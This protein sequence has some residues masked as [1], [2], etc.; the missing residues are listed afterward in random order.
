M[1]ITDGVKTVSIKMHVSDAFAGLSPDWSLDFFEA[2]SLHYDEETDTYSVPD[3]EYCIDQAK[4][5]E[6]ESENNIVFVC[7]CQER[8][9]K[10]MTIRELAAYM[11]EHS[12]VNPVPEIDEDTA[13]KYISWF[14]PD[15]TVPENLNPHDFMVEWNDIVRNKPTE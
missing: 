1:K 6:S 9:E 8:E 7:E 10:N 4:D 15:I 14:D 13:T 12:D 5:W 11:I 2:G 3:V